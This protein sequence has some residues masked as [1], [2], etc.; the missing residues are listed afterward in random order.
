MH[1]SSVDD[2]DGPPHRRRADPLPRR[3]VGTVL[4]ISPHPDDEALGAPA[5][6]LL[7]RRAGWRVVNAVV[8][9]GHTDDHRA[10]GARR[11]R[12]PGVRASSCGSPR[13]HRPWRSG[14][15]RRWTSS[16]P[17]SCSLP[18]PIDAHPRHEATSTGGSALRV[19]GGGRPAG[20]VAV[21]VVGRPALP[22]AV[23][24]LRRRRARRGAAR[25][26][27]V[28]GR[29]RAQRLAAVLLE[30]ATVA[31]AV[32]GERPRLRLRHRTCIRRALPE[33][34]TECRLVDGH[35]QPC[36]PRLLDPS[37]PASDLS[38]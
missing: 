15:G 24:A 31:H 6:L 28:H 17:H 10:D 27:R 25:A 38:R 37:A 18:H 7:L 9:L 21:G 5:T 4:H 16:R 13:T 8:S 36:D 32:F 29:A 3:G 30:A 11:W 35:W 14:S 2:H 20:V 22:H 1:H 19:R 33:L 23:R 34:L 26:R 12:R